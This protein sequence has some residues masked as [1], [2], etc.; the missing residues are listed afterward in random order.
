MEAIYRAV[1]GVLETEVG[2]IGGHVPNASYEQVCSGGTGHAEAVHVTFDP[3]K[4]EYAQLLEIFWENHDPTQT[5]GQGVNIG[6]QYRSAVFFH[7]IEQQQIAVQS[8]DALDQS[9]RFSAPITTGIV[10]SK[11]F[12]RAEDY[13]QHYLEKKGLAPRR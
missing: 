1:D 2:Y 5:N 10:V 12:V 6:D 4:V 13:H 7:S 3:S 8:R 11:D 9:G